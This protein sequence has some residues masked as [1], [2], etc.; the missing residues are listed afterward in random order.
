MKNQF[1]TFGGGCFWGVEESLQ[2]TEGVIDAVSG[3]SGGITESPNYKSICDGN[4][5]HAEVVQVEFNPE[6]ITY[7]QLV[8]R[9]MNIHDATDKNYANLDSKSQYRSIILF[10]NEEQ[11]HIA[12]NVINEL[13]TKISKNIKT[14]IVPLIK[15]HKA[16]DYHQ[17]YYGACRI[18]S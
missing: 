15:F 1:A 11:K 17:D 4:T 13:Q 10:H 12:V 14:E 8:K 5:A 2:K 7:E 18:S 3:Y 9:F 6:Q 16:E